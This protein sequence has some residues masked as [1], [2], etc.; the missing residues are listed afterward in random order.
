MR[1][2]NLVFGGLVF[3][4]WLSLVSPIAAQEVAVKGSIGGTVVDATGAVISGARITIAGPTGTK[5]VTTDVEG[6]FVAP[7]LIPGKYN[8]RAETAGF[9]TIQLADVEVFVGRQST[10]RL[11]F[12]VGEVSETVQVTS[13]TSGI[14]ITTTTTGANLNDT[15]YQQIPLQRNIVDL[16]YLASG[17]NDS[18]RG[19][20]QNPSISGGSALENLYIADGVNITDSAFGGLGTFSRVYGS[21]GT[22]INAS[23]IKEVEVKTGGFEPQYGKATGGI[24]NIITKS[25]SRDFH[26]ALF[27]YIQPNQFEAEREQ[28]DDFRRNK[29]GKILNQSQ[30]DFGAEV[31][32]YVPGLRD[33]LLWFGSFNPSTPRTYVLG[34]EGSGLKRLFGEITR[35]SLIY[36]YAFKTIYKVNPNNSVEFSIFGDPTRTNRAPQRALTADNDTNMSKLAYGS[37]NIN[38]RYNGTISPTLIL[39]GSFSYGFNYFR[40]G[41][42]DPSYFISDLTQ[43]RGL[44]GQRGSFVAVGLGFF[45]PTES[46]HFTYSIDASKRYRFLGSSHTF[47]IGFQYERSR[48]SGFRGVSG[49][50]FNIPSTN[51]AGDPAT[52]FGVP[53]NVV[54]LP[55]NATFSL[56]LAPPSCTLCP[57]KM[58]PG[59]GLVPVVLR[60]GGEFG[61]TSF[62]THAD[63]Y[64][65]YGVDSWNITSRLTVKLGLRWEENHLFG[66][67]VDYAFTDAWSPRIG[68]I[69]DPIGDRKTKLYFNFGRYFYNIPLDLAERSLS[70]ERGIFNALFAPDFTVDSQ[71]RRIARINRFDTVTPVLDA[72]HLL[73]RARGGINAPIFISEQSGESIV[74][75][76]KPQYEDEYVAGFEH[77]FRGGIVLSVRY[78]DRRLKRIV[79]DTGGVSP[80]AALA[81][82]TQIYQI[83]NVSSRT[84][85]FT[86]PI[87]HI[88]SNPNRLPGQCDPNLVAEVSDIFGKTLGFVCFEANGKNGQ[89]AG[90]AIPDG[91]P[92]GFPDPVRNYRAVEIEF[93][94]RFS[95]NFLLL[96]NWRISRLF[97][98]FEGAFRND[99]GQTDPSISSLFD[100]SEGSFNLLGDQFKPGVLNTDRRHVVNIYATYVFSRSKLKNFTTGVGV[101]L[102]SGQPINDLKAHPVYL[103][104]GEIPVNGRGSLGRHAVSGTVNL[105]FDYP[106]QITE[107]VRLRVGCDL[108]NIGN[109]KRVRRFDQSEDIQFGVKNIDF[110]QPAVF[111]NPFSARVSVRLEF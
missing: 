40:E 33:S 63:Y 29:R 53:A 22:G 57:L 43:T 21:L 45:E 61:T 49:P 103:N 37:R 81:G 23:F 101:R 88:F 82:I 95:K 109:S 79:E 35:R 93:N 50:S 75:G 54:G 17:V 52:S 25:G 67:K 105:H 28:P 94:R 4:F 70:N 8:V 62:N 55:S 80:E 18:D 41:G 68:A 2:K 90:S 111:Q 16:F 48:Y 19:G 76:T 74:A 47:D 92:D 97:G 24:V 13:S 71:G 69:Y 3:C 1:T 39:S 107:R 7:L 30:F 87:G 77:E 100:F 34:A 73:N 15:L 26:G 66:G 65:G 58:V 83:G 12:E 32:G 72:A 44:P 110:R 106:Y 9:K 6:N 98:N 56:L 85:L 78:I 96:A 5:E 86:N 89:P 91:I 104:G 51:A 38:V 99:N 102:A 64:A 59:L 108:F 36:N 46:K 60:Q 42:F 31:S 20:F 84:D 10:V 14:D 27:G 11:V